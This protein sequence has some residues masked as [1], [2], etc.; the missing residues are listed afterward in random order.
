VREWRDGGGE[1]K[2]P[3][4]K[5]HGESG[6]KRGLCALFCGGQTD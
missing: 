3:G 2:N 1:K 5:E 4:E 6:G